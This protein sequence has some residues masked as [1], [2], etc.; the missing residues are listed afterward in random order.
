MPGHGPYELV[1]DPEVRRHISKVDKKYHSLIR[2]EIERQLRHEPEAETKN[3]KP[4]LRPSVL[5]SAW[6]LRFGPDNRFRV[7]YRADRALRR[8]YILAVGVKIK[9]RLLIGREE[10]EL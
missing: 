4:L 6:E 8:V 9:S 10:F 7:Y 3:R 1:Y 2:R 5:D